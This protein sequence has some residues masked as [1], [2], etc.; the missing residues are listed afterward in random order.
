MTSLAPISVPMSVEHAGRD[1]G[2]DGQHDERLTTLP[3]AHDLHAGD[4]D[5]GLTEQAADRA[6]DTGTVDVAEER[7]VLGDR[8][9]EVEAVDA[10][11]LLDLARAGQ[12]ARDR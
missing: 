2:V 11:D 4:V 3:V 8:H 9:L 10:D 12:G 7:H 1:G 6:D 5:V